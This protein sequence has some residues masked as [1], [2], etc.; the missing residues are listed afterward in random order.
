MADTNKKNT[1]PPPPE[2][3][4]EA[5][6]IVLAGRGQSVLVLPE[7]I[8]PA[9]AEI[10]QD[11]MDLVLLMPDGVRI[12]IE[13]FFD[14]DPVPRLV[15]AGGDDVPPDALADL[16]EDGQLDGIEEINELGVLDEEASL[17]AEADSLRLID[18]G[19]ELSQYETDAG[20]DGDGGT[21]EAIPVVDGD[22]TGTAGVAPE[23]LEGFEVDAYERV[24]DGHPNEDR[25]DPL[26][27]FDTDETDTADGDE[28]ETVADSGG[29]EEKNEPE[30]EP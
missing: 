19:S 6:V 21:T 29:T 14:N 18:D 15:T 3:G 2:T 16:D 22:Y 5:A 30:A 27:Q 8:D 12:I 25:D 7:G 24:I 26:Y 13:A 11:G 9:D 20:T 10:F 1:R 17:Q 23:E 4:E 28:T